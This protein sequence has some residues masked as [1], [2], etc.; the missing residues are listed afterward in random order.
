MVASQSSQAWRIAAS[1]SGSRPAEVGAFAFVG[2]DVEQ[3]LVAVHLQVLSNR[4]S[5][6]RALAP[7]LHAP[8]QRAVEAG[9]SGSRST[10]LHRHTIQCAVGWSSL[11]APP[12]SRAV[13]ADQSIVRQCLAR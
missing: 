2:R 7:V 13:V 1:F 10:G 11:E 3:V 4:P 5:P 12:T 8:V 6:V 9:V